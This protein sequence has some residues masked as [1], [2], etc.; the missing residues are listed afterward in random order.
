MFKW[1]TGVLAIAGLVCAV[2]AP[3]AAQLETRQMGGVGITVFV[4]S[5]YRGNNATFRN[6]QPDL[7]P[8]GFSGNIS[9]LQIPRGE[10]WEACQGTSYRPPCQVFSG[11]ESDLRRRNWNDKIASLRR[12]QGGGGGYPGGGNPGGRGLVL[13]S[14][15]NFRG[16]TRTITGA[17]PELGSYNDKAKSV[18]LLSGVWE[19]CEDIN[20]GKCRTIDRDWPDLSGLGLTKRISSARPASGRGGGGYPPPPSSSA[21]LVMY[22][23]ESYRGGSQTVVRPEPS[24][25]SAGG[26]AR[27]IQIIGTWQLCEGPNFSGRCVTVN[28]NVPDLNAYGIA[29]PIVSARPMGRR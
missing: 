21:R 9:S 16:S 13:Y 7:G 8:S 25:G 14:D 28:Q 10:T 2:T 27:S 17:T 5:D 22:D 3:L 6:D 19:V 11:T 15:E 20:Y 18:R 29:N 24:L 4:D 23:R 12:V 1:K 26:R